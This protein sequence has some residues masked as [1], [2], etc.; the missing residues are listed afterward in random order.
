MLRHGCLSADKLLI[1]RLIQREL[2]SVVIVDIS[3]ISTV[4]LQISTMIIF[5]LILYHLIVLL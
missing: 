4:A 1:H 2:T 5:L 3:R